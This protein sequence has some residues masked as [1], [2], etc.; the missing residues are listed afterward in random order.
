LLVT[1]EVSRVVCCSAAG[2]QSAAG[3]ATSTAGTQMSSTSAGDLISENWWLRFSD[4]RLEDYYAVQARLDNDAGRPF[5]AVSA[6][7]PD[8]ADLQQ[9]VDGKAE[10]FAT[11]LRNKSLTLRPCNHAPNLAIS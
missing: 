2:R 10:T 5:P 7:T 1:A 8:L 11:D 6:N 3:A 4:Y 9:D